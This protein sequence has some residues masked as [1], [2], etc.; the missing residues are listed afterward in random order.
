MM[1]ASIQTSRPDYADRA[2]LSG[3]V[4]PAVLFAIIILC[5]AWDAPG[6]VFYGN[7]G[8]SN[9]SVT[10][11][12][13]VA[14]QACFVLLFA[15]IAASGISAGGVDFLRSIP[16]LFWPIL[17]WMWLSLAWAIDPSIAF[18]RLTFTTIVI[19]SIAYA[20]EQMT[21]RQVI[22]LLLAALALILVL[23]WLAVALFPLAVHQTGELD[24]SLVG[25]WR[26]IHNHK[27]E[28][29]A[30]CAI[31]LILFAH[32]AH[33]VRS[34]MTGPALIALTSVF[35]YQTHS[36]TSGGFVFAALLIG[37]AAHLAYNN[38]ALRRV[39]AFAAIFLALVV[40]VLVGNPL[41]P[42]A[43]L[44]D[45][46]AALTGRV[47]IWP[48]LIQ[49]AWDH[50]WLGAGYGSFWAIGD[51]SPIYQYGSGWV[52]T[53]D[54]AHNGYIQVLIQTGVI[55]LA[56]VTGTLI[57]QPFRRLFLQELQRGTSRFLIC[58]I[59]AF[60]CLHDLLET[61]ILDRATSTWVIMLIMYCLLA[62]GLPRRDTTSVGAMIV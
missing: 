21:Y 59:L 28:A 26:G 10:A 43:Q 15:A 31:A 20:I 36:K 32:E 24:P 3:F 11:G 47:Q 6:I 33:R 58:A 54:H 40:L 48:V 57:V 17:G 16:Q 9:T 7:I 44:F 1:S 25:N 42:A 50:V 34:T 30:F 62:K 5:Y 13:D 61:S 51:A 41:S 55:G 52:T 45:D 19:L 14:R 2:A 12:G 27:N 49:Y 39:A 38:P 60:G 18:R 53:V 35:L 37:A 29:G 23:D 46:P 8:F 4:P 22:R 56:I